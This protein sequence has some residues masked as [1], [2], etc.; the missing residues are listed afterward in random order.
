LKG[1]DHTAYWPIGFLDPIFDL[2]IA[3]KVCNFLMRLSL[4]KKETV[5]AVG[6]PAR[7]KN[8]SFLVTRLVL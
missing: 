6:E 3:L 8:I 4:V 2:A 5:Y 7:L 1:C